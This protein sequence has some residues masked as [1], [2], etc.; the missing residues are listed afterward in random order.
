MAR[1]EAAEVRIADK[2]VLIAEQRAALDYLQLRL[3]RADEERAKTQVQ[4][5]A[6]LSD[7]RAT[8]PPSARRTWWPWRW[9]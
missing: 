6:L 1:L 9:R 3:T 8:T 5:A 4:L 2:D 7:Q